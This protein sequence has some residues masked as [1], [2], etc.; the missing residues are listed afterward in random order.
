MVKIIVDKMWIAGI[1]GDMASFTSWSSLYTTF[2]NALATMTTDQILTRTWTDGDGQVVTL[3]SMG[4]IMAYE[5][6]L[7]QKMDE[8]SNTGGRRKMSFVAG[9]GGKR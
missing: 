1:L 9:Y 7:K 8:E 4:D 3:R 2:K 5:R 6:F